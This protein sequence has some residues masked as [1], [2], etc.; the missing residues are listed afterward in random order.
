MSPPTKLSQTKIPEIT[1]FFWITKITA[2]TLG[3]TGGDLLAQTM[4]V[5]YA[6]STII[7]LGVMLASLVGQLRAKRFS[8]A[9][10][11]TVIA[12]TSMA[13]TTISDYMDRTLKLGYLR[14]SAFLVVL[15]VASL[16]F[17]KVKFGDLSITGVNRF[18]IELMFWTTVLVANTLGTALGDWLS[19]N[20]GL[21][22]GRATVVIIALIALTAYLHFRTSINKVVLF[23][24][25]FVLIQPFG[26]TAGDLWT[27]KASIGGMGFPTY[28]ASGILLG[29]LV[30]CV[31]LSNA[32]D[33]GSGAET[34][35]EL[36]DELVLDVARA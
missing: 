6:V 9:L 12:T 22:F 30:L 16:V 36:G 21:G 18:S 25:G 17:W 1:L 5:G 35:S 32:V 27:K 10:Y 34:A 19:D 33:G 26:A 14:G 28:Y 31:V 13:G 4:K 20:T 2:T 7:F 11:W 24:A 15:L 29:I 3:E 8:P 23:W